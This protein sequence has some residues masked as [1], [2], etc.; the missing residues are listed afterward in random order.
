MIKKGDAL[1]ISPAQN[2][3]VV[4][5]SNDFLHGS[6]SMEDKLVFISI[7]EVSEFMLSHFNQ[8]AYPGDEKEYDKE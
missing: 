5:S 6:D 7:T 2:G 8:T 1:L 4:E 3:F